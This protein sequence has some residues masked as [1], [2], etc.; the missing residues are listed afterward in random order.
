MT[1]HHL[2][3]TLMVPVLLFAAPTTASAQSISLRHVHGLA[4]SSDGKRLMIPSHHG[5][6]VYQDG[7]WAK[8]PGPEHDYMGFSATARNLYSSGHPAPGSG[9]VNPFGLMRSDD[10]GRPGT[11][12]ASR[13]KPISTCSQPAGATTR[14][15]SGILRQAQG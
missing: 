1:L 10:G 4:Y 12:W 8:A 14:S 5:L 2:F 6:A 9:L 15:M 11:S 3:A 7:K 13:A